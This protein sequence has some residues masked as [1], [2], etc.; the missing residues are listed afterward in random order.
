MYN[1]K[2]ISSNLDLLED[3]Y[4]TSLREYSLG[5]VEEFRVRLSD[6]IG[7]SGEELRSITSE[8]QAYIFNELIM[9]PASFPY[10]A[11]RYSYVHTDDGRLK[12][13]EIWPSQQMLLNKIQER[14]EKN[15]RDHVF[16][17][18]LKGRQE[19]ITT[20]S[21][22]IQAHRLMLHEGTRSL[23][24]SN[25]ED[26]TF[27]LYQ[28]L[29]RIYDNLPWWMKPQ[30][31]DRVKSKHM[32]FP[33]LRSKA[34]YA[35]S[36]QADPIGQGQTLDMVH[37]TEVSTWV[38]PGY[39]KGDIEPAFTS[40]GAYLP[41]FIAESTGEGAKGNY[42]HDL[43]M[44][45]KHK[46]GGFIPLFI[47]VFDLPQKYHNS[48]EGITLS[49]VTL[50]V[51]ERWEREN[52]KKLSKE[53]LAWY[54]NTRTR[55]EGTGDLETFFQEYP[56]TEEEAFQV[57][58]KSVF[59]IELR[60]KLR[61]EVRE[62][63]ALYDVNPA[64]GKL[65]PIEDKEDKGTYNRLVMWEMPER[66]Q[67]YVMGVD[68]SWG[69]G[70]ENDNASIEVIR[71]GT[72]ERPD[73]QVAE[74]Y[75]DVTPSHLAN[76]ANTVGWIYE[77]KVEGL[78]AMASVEAQPGTPGGITQEDLIKKGYPYFYN[79]KRMGRRPGEGETQILGWYTTHQSRPA[80]T[81]AGV[82]A[83]KSRDLYVNSTQVLTE[84]SS[85]VAHPKRLGMTNLKFLGHADGYH[86][87][88]LIALF[89]AFYTAHEKDLGIVA[90]ERKKHLSLPQEK[91]DKLNPLEYD[92]GDVFEPYV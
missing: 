33:K 40:S 51:G 3:L 39:I 83:I 71:V 13:V 76:I 63:E 23:A 5:E 7:P 6:V 38:N 55:Y 49:P 53:Q 73:E 79:W 27:E 2:V 31:A 4:K 28:F 88:C 14:E 41:I 84:M 62:P 42:F 81:Q 75:G 25:V 18:A 1:P 92:T 45:A 57:G 90:D 56:T 87:D 50:A 16:I 35:W 80:L 78:P 68:A 61:D 9:T 20:I 22:M 91:R 74:F 89:I 67:L 77:D 69:L 44:S 26:K 29:N 37:L 70:G 82:D 43:Y 59:S 46:G 10:W 24:A 66:G 17:A 36:N 48:T 11:D 54:Q 32:V 47:S 86:D 58:L 15:T 65:I 85:F 34:N 12:K 60:S 64:N 72:K 8:E 30:V 21:Q 52:G 19:G